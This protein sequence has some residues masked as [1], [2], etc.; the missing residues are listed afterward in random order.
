MLSTVKCL[1]Q[2]TRC[3][4][5]KLYTKIDA[6]QPLLQA[7]KRS[8]HADLSAPLPSLRG[9]GRESRLSVGSYAHGQNSISEKLSGKLSLHA[10]RE[11]ND[12]PTD[13]YDGCGIVVGCPRLSQDN[14]LGSCPL[15][16]SNGMVSTP[17]SPRLAKLNHPSLQPS[18]EG[19]ILGHR[20]S[21]LDGSKHSLIHASTTDALSG[22]MPE[23]IR[24]QEKPRPPRNAR[25]AREGEAELSKA[26]LS[27]K[28]GQ[29]V[30][31]TPFSRQS[32]P[33]SNGNGSENSRRNSAVPL[34]DLRSVAHND[35]GVS[36]EGF[37]VQRGALTGMHV[38]VGSNSR[39]G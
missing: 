2:V 16:K 39:R 4:T 24:V 22:P 30:S 27:S 29:D 36:R 12:S 18:M 26:D 25:N 17:A 21:G 11:S 23:V 10:S 33:E 15:P 32:V 37:G 38:P 3:L 6:C 20:F 1:T 13:M 34:L 28:E 35:G 5:L 9:G 31:W 8:H 7:D 19:S 14:S